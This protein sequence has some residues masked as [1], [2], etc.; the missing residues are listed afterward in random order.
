MTTFELLA[1]LRGRNIKLW[2]EGDRLRFQAPKGALTD[3]LRAALSEHKAEVL[4]LLQEVTATTHEAPAPI[5]RAPNRDALPLSYAQQRLW[6]LDQLEPG[7]PFYSLPFAVRLSG[8]LDVAV[9]ERAFAALIA[10]H[11]ALRTTFVAH[12]GQPVQVIAP[13]AP[14]PLPLVDLRQLPGAE[15]EAATQ[16]HMRAEAY[17][18]FD[19]QRGPLLRTTLLQLA[20]TDY[21]V[22]VTLHHIIADGWSIGILIRD[23]ATLYA[24]CAADLPSPLP[25]LPVQYADFAHWQRQSLTDQRLQQLLTAW[26][27]Q[28]HGAPTTL[29][30]PT[31][32]PRPPV[33][34]V[35]G[36]T[37]PVRLPQ[38]LTQALLTLS[39]QHGATLFMTLLAA[40]QVLL[41]R[42]SGQDQL[43]VG[44]PIAGRTRAELDELIGCF[45]NTLVLRADL[46]GQPTF[47]A[48]LARVRTTTLHAYEHQELPFERLV[49]AI[50]PARDLS[51]SPLVQVMFALHN[52]PQEASALPGLTLRRL[53][54]DSGTA[55]F[56]LALSLSETADGL[57]GTLEY[58]T[59][60]FARASMERLLSH[61]HTLLT[62]IVADPQQPIT[63]LPLLTDV[64]RQQLLVD[65]NATAA[66]FPRDLCL[67]QLVEAQ[68]AEHP[69]AIAIAC[70]EQS[71]TYRQLD[72]R[73]NQL[74]HQ[75]QALGV[76][77]DVCVGLLLTRSPDLAIA[78]LGVLKAGGAYLPIDIAY[79]P[80]RIQFMLEDAR[81]PILLTQSHLLQAAPAHKLR[82]ICLD[83][84][85]TAIAQQPET[86]PRSTATAEHLAYVIYTSGSTG[87]PK[88]VGVPHRGAINLVTWHRRTYDLSPDDR[89]T[90]L[91][92][93]AFDASV[94]ELWPYLA[95]GASLHLPDEEIRSAPGALVEWLIAQGITICFMP[96]PLAEAVL[97]EQRAAQLPLRALLTGGDVLHAHEWSRLPFLVINHYGPT[98]NTVVTT[99]EAV[100]AT[101][102]ALP[103]IGRPIANTQVYLLDSNLQPVP[104][105]V[106]GQLYIGGDSLARGY[107]S[108]PALTAER[109]VPNPFGGSLER[110]SAGSRL[111]STG[112]LGRYLPDGRIDFLGR[113]DHQVKIRGFR[114]ELG[115]IE[116]ALLRHPGLRDG[117]VVAREDSS[118]KRLVAYVVENLEPR[119]K[120]LEDESETGSRTPGGHP[121]LGSTLRT[122]LGQH[123]PDYMLPSAFVT[124]DALPLTP[125]GKV[126]RKALPAP[127]GTSPEMI[128][129]APRTPTEAVLVDLWSDVLGAEQI[130]VH[131]NFFALGGHSLLATQLVSRIRST[132]S[133]DLPLRQVF[134][135]PTVAELA[136]H[137]ATLRADDR[138][139]PDASP[140]QLIDRSTP[141]P[142]S[143]SQERLWF[144]DQ[145]EP[146][147]AFYSIPFAVRLS[148]QLDVAVLERAF[149]ALIARHEALRTTFVARDGQPVQVIAP[150]APLP[151]PLVDLRQL[152]GAEREATALHYARTEAYTPFDLQRG[153]LL[154][155]TLLQLAATDYVVLV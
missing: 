46:R 130:G 126:D 55:K 136:Q 25:P 110:T 31:D 28:L 32:H 58:A 74:A 30:L 82:T 96:T 56:D 27:D 103:S 67:T 86:P 53:P 122:F 38:S 77:P 76:R 64:Q 108:R 80:E 84:D 98:E 72:R 147:S 34:S 132:L 153:P 8:Q 71:L 57:V 59:A 73:A 22:L 140:I 120:N 133:V 75:L 142:L 117:V 1:R 47:V 36:A 18:P 48:L 121:V 144:L 143:F 33:Q 14:L 138:S 104:I 151:L 137:I 131:D 109:F 19:L 102:T 90:L 29:E 89:A 3:E 51:R 107:L 129:V 97:A 9:L 146:G 113:I 26:I 83:T 4:A 111:Y 99:C 49:E 21:V 92:G 123:L 150:P 88:G 37:L 114:I 115:E 93:L 54:V 39:Q 45:V 95:S 155:T 85:W 119:T 87:R 148:G 61:F 63:T 44:S 125:N 81:A 101:S 135:A 118:E 20:A 17:T 41:A 10:R 152:P 15:R 62:A 50:Q 141:L 11:E 42:V 52:T 94:W 124:L 127:D 2:A 6:F 78:A 112:D 23:L 69:E 116:A 13:P 66:W 65:W 43:L 105:G 145:L 134:A 5:E 16:K 100:E 35:H 106:T 60:L 149:A 24:A 70:A 68:A 12:D 91:A 7:S 79:P 128:F 154:R 40:F 139:Q